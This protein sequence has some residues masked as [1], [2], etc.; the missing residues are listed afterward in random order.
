MEKTRI[1]TIGRK[2]GSGGREIAKL[3]ADKLGIAYYD[4]EIITNAAKESG[5]CDDFLENFE[6]TPTGSLLYSM[7]MNA[8]N[9]GFYMNKP[10]E[11]VAYEA[12]VNA[13]K[14]AAKNGPC[15]IVGR[16]ASYLLRD[17]YDILSVFVTAPVDYR[18][19]RIMKRDSLSKREAQA[20]I[21]R[22]DK[23]RASYHNYYADTKWGAADTYDLCINTAKISDED[24]A[25]LILRYNETKTF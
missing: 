10:I 17:D 19:E 7:V 12:Q 24:A 25:E 3:V 9:G 2:Y 13:V 6:Q 18:M 1:I 15:V 14:N 23:A 20:Q 4:K 5:L 11:L 16:C 22:M 21:N 8:Q